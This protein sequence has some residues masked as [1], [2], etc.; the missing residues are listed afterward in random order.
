[1]G[2]GP[3]F[4]LADLCPLPDAPGG[5][6]MA[7]ITQHTGYFDDSE[8][9]KFT[10]LGGFVA[11]LENWRTVEFGWRAILGDAGLP[12]LHMKERAKLFKK[13]AGDL[14]IQFFQGVI[15]TI[16][17]A[18]IRPFVSTVRIA[19]LNRFNAERARSVDAYGLN[20]YT[21]M[22]MM[23]LEFK[24]EPIQVVL[25]RANDVHEKANAGRRYA[26]ACHA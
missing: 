18:R 4:R 20:L 10:S 13:V 16:Q 7:V 2:S 12:Y 9:S 1:M 8:D 19:D 22:A 21:C 14:Q 6:I 26:A 24:G 25:D 17:S 5:W 23:R 15:Q 11:P 3:Q